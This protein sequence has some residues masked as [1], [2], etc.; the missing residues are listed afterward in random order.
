[1]QP[2][3]LIQ[4]YLIGDCTEEEV[5]E[6]ERRLRADERLQDAFL[7]EAEIDAHLRQEAQLGGDQTEPIAQARKQ[8]RAI[9]KWV[10][11][12]STLAATILLAVVLLNFPPQKTAMAFPSLGSVEVQLPLADSIWLAAYTANRTMLDDELRNGVS[13]D[14]KLDDELTPLHVAALFGQSGCDSPAAG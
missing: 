11:G 8:P 1:M 12:I 5:A 9:W 4:R 13:V 3:D 6:L 14:A 2:N 10:S 7:R